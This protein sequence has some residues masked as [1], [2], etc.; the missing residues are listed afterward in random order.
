[1]I[2]A[3]TVLVSVVAIVGASFGLAW[4]LVWA[5]FMDATGEDWEV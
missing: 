2:P 3:L 5:G 1:M 4:Y